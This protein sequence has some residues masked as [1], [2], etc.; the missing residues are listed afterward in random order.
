MSRRSVRGRRYSS[1]RTIS[2]EGITFNGSFKGMSTKKTKII[3]RGT[4]PLKKNTVAF[5]RR[6]DGCVL[7]VADMPR[8]ENGGG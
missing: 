8:K 1:Y 6:E 7:E 5:R 3:V 4:K 2:S